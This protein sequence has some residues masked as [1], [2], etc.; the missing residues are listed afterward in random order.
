MLGPVL[1]RDHGDNTATAKVDPDMAA[2][3]EDPR[4]QAMVSSAEA[5]LAAG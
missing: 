3:R 4:F 5:R 1:E 2:L